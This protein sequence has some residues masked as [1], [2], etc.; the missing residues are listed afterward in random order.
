MKKQPIIKDNTGF[1][2]SIISDYILDTLPFWHNIGFT[3]NI[4]TTLGFTSTSIC[5]VL[6]YKSYILYSIFFLLLRWYFDYADGMLARKYKETSKFG[7]WYDHITDWIF[8]SGFL[9]ITYLKSN[10]K[11][12]HISM[13]LIA[14]ILFGIHQGCIEKVNTQYNNSQETSL[15]RTRHICVESPFTSFFDNTILYLVMIYLI[16]DINK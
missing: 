4:L 14:G 9:Y 12:F 5:L 1:F 13:L 7:D 15:S 6:Y 11:T 2:D 16:Y 3:P 10:T 8:F